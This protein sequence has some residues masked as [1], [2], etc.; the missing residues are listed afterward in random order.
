MAG[1]I[2]IRRADVFCSIADG[3]KEAR[4]TLAEAAPRPADWAKRRDRASGRADADEL[5][6]IGRGMFAWLDR[7]GRASA[8][9]GAP[10]DDRIP[11]VKAGSGACGSERR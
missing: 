11:G 9:A 6:A 5:A 7:E 4:L 3:G 2:E 8:W 1:L 10:G